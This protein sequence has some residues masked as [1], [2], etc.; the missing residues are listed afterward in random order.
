[1]YNRS[2]NWFNYKI[3][4]KIKLRLK[5][6]NLDINKRKNLKVQIFQEKSKIALKQIKDGQY[7]GLISTIMKN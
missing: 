3:K 5:E 6:S 7:T 1:M 2:C 4:I